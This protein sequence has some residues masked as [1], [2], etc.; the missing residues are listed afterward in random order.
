LLLFI[1]RPVC[2]KGQLTEVFS[3]ITLGAGVVFIAC[4][5]GKLHTGRFLIFVN[6][7]FAAV[8]VF[9]LSMLCC[10]IKYRLAAESPHSDTGVLSQAIYIIFV[11]GLI[12]VASFEWA[13]HCKYNLLVESNLHYI[14]RG[15]SI[16]LAMALLL[17]VVRPLCP[18]GKPTA[19]FALIALTAGVI[20]IACVLG[21]LHTEKF[22]I[23]INWDFAAVFVFLMS[24]LYFHIKFRLT[25]E[26]P[27]SEAGAV[28]QAIYAVFGLL[29]ITVIIAEWYWHCVFNL[30]KA[31]ISPQLFRGFI[32]ILAAGILGFIVRPLCPE[33][34]FSRIWASGLAIVGSLFTVILYTTV[35][36][37]GFLIF[38]NPTFAAACVFIA[39][40]F[41]SVYL[42]NRRKTEEPDAK[43]FTIGVS[44]LAV[45]FLW[46]VLS[47]EI[48]EYWRCRNVYISAIKNWFFIASMWMSVCWA[49]YGLVLLAIG[50]GRKLK[51]LRYIGLCILGALLLKA[52]IVDMREVSTVYRILAFL[53]TGV[54][55]VGVSYLY[56][57][58]KNKGFFEMAPA[59]SPFNKNS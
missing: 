38:I 25:S 47:E 5:L 29:F 15:Q 20:F 32:I 39:S 37:N 4:V 40:L 17:F 3:L 34:T 48:Y 14:S 43:F 16:I 10:H 41:V 19:A 33:G 42:L 24:I 46:V 45:I 52:F 18:L 36:N 57:F 7:D 11:L 12:S 22:L 28:S 31:G 35:H 53:A 58:L 26:S 44:L 54:T 49:I 27:K 55:L 6:W 56:Q 51:V 8:L 9:L 13:A 50:F 59:R 2:P 30:Q 23:F 21:K 1:I